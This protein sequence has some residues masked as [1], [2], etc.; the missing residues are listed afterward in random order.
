M[1]NAYA[2]YQEV[3]AKAIELQQLVIETFPQGQESDPTGGAMFEKACINL[4][5]AVA[6]AW[7]R[8]DE[9]CFFLLF[10]Q[11]GI[12]SEVELAEY[13]SRP[14]VISLAVESSDWPDDTPKAETAL[15]AEDETFAAKYLPETHAGYQRLCGLF[16]EGTKQYADLRRTAL[17][18]GATRARRELQM[19]KIRLEEI[20]ATSRARLS[21]ATVG[22]EKGRRRV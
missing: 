2:Q 5:K 9:L 13:D 18:L 19:F 22:I 15:A 21:S 7:R 20:Q 17:A 12:F 1:P 3:R 8:H 14:I 4:L 10:H 11:A 16:D 6:R